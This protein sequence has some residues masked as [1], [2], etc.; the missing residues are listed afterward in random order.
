MKKQN[1][2]RL[3]PEF[4]HLQPAFGSLDQIFALQG[5]TVTSERISDLIRV[6]RD[7]EVYYVKRYRVAGKGIRR[8]LGKPRIQSEWQNLLWFAANGIATATVVACGMEKKWGLF[9][10]GALITREIPQTEDLAKLARAND[11]RLQDPNWVRQISLQ[12]AEML[13]VMHAKQFVHNDFK[14]RNLLVDNNNKLYVIDCPLGAFWRGAWFRYR[15]LKELAMLDRVAKYKLR[16]SQRLRFYLQYRD[17][18][19]LAADD[20]ILLRKLLNRKVRRKS[21]FAP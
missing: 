1:Q 19:R 17:R 7:S 8:F 12:A 13:R 4:M 9:R 21:S 20:K 10:R 2:W 5:E 6:K 18:P 15:R 14:W 3:L 16:R 11:K